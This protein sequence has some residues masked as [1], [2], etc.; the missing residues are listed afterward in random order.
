M[1]EKTAF[2][3]GAATGIGRGLVEKLDRLGI[4]VTTLRSLAGE[5][6]P[7]LLPARRGCPAFAHA[8]SSRCRFAF[9][10]A[11]SLRPSASA[12]NADT[13]STRTGS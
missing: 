9:A 4:E 8:T 11:A 7:A 5:H 1:S 6:I 12:R 13:S 3:T 2:V 10:H